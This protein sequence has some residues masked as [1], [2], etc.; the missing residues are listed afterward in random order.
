MLD[1]AQTVEAVFR[2]LRVREP[3]VLIELREGGTNV[4]SIQVW[5]R[6]HFLDCPRIVREATDLRRWWVDHL[7]N[8]RLLTHHRLTLR[9]HAI[10][11]DA[12]GEREWRRA[13]LASAETLPQPHLETRTEWLRRA[14]IMYDEIEAI[15]R[16]SG[17]RRHV[18][19]ILRTRQLRRHVEWFVDVQLRGHRPA[20]VARSARVHKS[21]VTRAWREICGVI[22]LT[23]RALS[24][25][26]RGA[27]DSRPRRTRRDAK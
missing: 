16:P 17:R 25:S 1:C 7:T 22:G 14:R 8:A 2:V 18:L 20:D 3:D 10:Y 27:M 5:A 19:K 4:A 11:S 24:P 12:P 23:P 13:M 6:H 21:R 9:V 15:C 26:R